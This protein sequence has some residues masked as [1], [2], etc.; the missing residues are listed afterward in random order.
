LI[1]QDR[2]RRI[3]RSPIMRHRLQ[4]LP[5]R[6]REEDAVDHPAEVPPY[7]S[8]YIHRH[9]EMMLARLSSSASL[10][11]SLGGTEPH[12]LTTENLIDIFLNDQPLPSTTSFTASRG[13]TMAAMYHPPRRGASISSRKRNSVRNKFLC[14]TTTTTTRA[15][16][17]A[18]R[19]IGNKNIQHK[20]IQRQQKKPPNRK[21]MLSGL[22][23]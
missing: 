23:R 1:G 13:P 16:A 17:T 6:K 8:L 3:A 11:R 10:W 12:D 20:R 19:P 22:H 2:H 9:H 4:T 7:H 21:F 18:S 14:A 5:N 15:T